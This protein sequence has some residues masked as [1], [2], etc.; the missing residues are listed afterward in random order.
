MTDW[1]RLLLIIGAGYCVALQLGKLPG[2]L[3]LLTG[4]LGLSIVLAGWLVSSVTAVS[5]LTGMVAGSF[6]QRYGA[7]RLLFA[8][9]AAGAAG[10]LIGAAAQG[11]TVLILSRLVEGAG[12]IL[13]VVSA[14]PLF[15]RVVAPR[16]MPTAM[17]IWATYVPAGMALALL[18]TPS[19]L[20]AL[21]WR[22]LWVANA[23]ILLLWL[24]VV[25]RAT[26]GLPPP[27]AMPPQPIVARVR[28]DLGALVAAR[29][30]L[31]LAL[32]FGAYASQFLAVMGFL[33]VLL[34]Q[35][36]G[37]SA[38]TA[39]MITGVVVALNALGNLLGGALLKRLL[40]FTL[41]ALGAAS[42]IAGACLV[43]AS[44][45]PALLRIAGAGLFSF[46]GGLVPS[47]AFASIP[48]L[49]VP[50]ETRPASFGLLIQAAGIGQLL[51]PPALAMVVQLGGSWDAAPLFTV[52]CAALSVAAFRMAT[53]RA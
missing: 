7:R 39:A 27:P 28:A 20:A 1:S 12:F 50:A 11:P 48:G 24:A 5:A 22:G 30:P 4:E 10:S 23:A 16:H 40:P 34:I 45:L 38:A 51:G 47:S 14:P 31:W 37:F 32:G 35:T 3:P 29:A 49:P 46:G 36:A 33:P 21:G 26:G 15:Q 13:T 9:L 41:L 2:A 6:A 53:R 18:G 17:A 43:F 44:P 42:M 19:G 52:A 25:W 8:G